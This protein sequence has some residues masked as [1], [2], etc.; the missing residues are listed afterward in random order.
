MERSGV[1]H[2][3]CG[4]LLCLD[5]FL[6]IGDLFILRKTSKPWQQL[7]RALEP[8]RPFWAS[9]VCLSSSTV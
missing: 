9:H 7:L 4:L 8:H 1:E 3:L 5:K 2:H 6:D